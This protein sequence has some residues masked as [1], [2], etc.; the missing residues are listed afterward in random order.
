MGVRRLARLRRPLDAR[1]GQ[2][3]LEQQ[4]RPAAARAPRDAQTRQVVDPAHPQRVATG[5]DQPDLTLPEMHEHDGV[6]RQQVTDVGVVVTPGLG[7]QQV[8]DRGIGLPA[9]HRLQA[10]DAAARPR[11]HLDR[12]ARRP[13]E[14]IER[15]VVAAGQPQPRPARQPPPRPRRA[16]VGDSRPGPVTSGDQSR[17]PQLAIRARHRARC[18]PQLCGQRP[19]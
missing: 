18:A 8:Q 9:R 15:R 16:A 6:P 13:H 19:R 11:D 1:L 10:V 3:P 4:P 2:Q 5:H 17:A 14:R 12:L 7:V